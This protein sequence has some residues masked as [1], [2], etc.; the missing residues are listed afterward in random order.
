M[1]AQEYYE[2]ALQLREEMG[3]QGT[4]AES[5]L[6][7]ARLELDQGRFEEARLDAQRA[8]EEFKQEKE[9]DQEAAGYA[10]LADCFVHQ[11]NLSQL[12]SALKRATELAP[13]VEDKDIHLFVAVTTARLRSTIGNASNAIRDLS[14]VWPKPGGSA[15]LAM[16]LKPAWRWERPRCDYRRKMLKAA[17]VSNGSRMMRHPRGSG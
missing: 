14:S 6:S 7:L 5:R 1:K 16:S 10:V 17:L 9:V 11:G 3:E 13:Q 12:E 15:T 2:E 8:I 4:I